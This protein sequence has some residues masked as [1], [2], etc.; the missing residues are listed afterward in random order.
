M[1]LAG[2]ESVWISLGQVLGVIIVHVPCRWNAA[3]PVAPEIHV[4]DRVLQELVRQTGV[5][6]W[7]RG[8]LLQ[9]VRVRYWNI[10][11][12]GAEIQ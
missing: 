4:L 7:E 6:C 9:R 3:E 8:Q 1:L 11:E 5:H 12:V 2:T 10:L